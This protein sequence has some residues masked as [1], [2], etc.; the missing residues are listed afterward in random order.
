MLLGKILLAHGDDTFDV[1]YND[2]YH[3]GV[4][5]FASLESAK[6]ASENIFKDH[7]DLSIGIIKTGNVYSIRK[8]DNKGSYQ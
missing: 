7:Q 1:S 2:L 4:K 8:F 3:D 5:S 6:R